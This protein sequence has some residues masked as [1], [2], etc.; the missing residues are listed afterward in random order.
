MGSPPKDNAVKMCSAR[1]NTFCTR[2]CISSITLM[3][4][5]I[6][7]GSEF[8]SWLCCFCAT[9]ADNWICTSTKSD[10]ISDTPITLKH[11]CPP[12]NL[13]L[14]PFCC[15]VSTRTVS[16]AFFCENVSSAYLRNRCTSMT[17]LAD[18][19]SSALRFAMSSPPSA[20]EK[21]PHS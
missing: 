19:S 3:R 6:S 17:I 18:L 13:N 5:A 10:S 14:G 16:E 11:V 9:M 15:P 12:A 20:N 1:S 2:L 21:R 4:S 8:E 7:V